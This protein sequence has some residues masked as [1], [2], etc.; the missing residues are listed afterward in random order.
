M[1]VSLILG[2]L[3]Q[4][5]PETIIIDQNLARGGP[6]RRHLY[7]HPRPIWQARPFL[8]GMEAPG[9]RCSRGAL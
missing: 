1:G 3:P 9:P 6:T 5:Y 8:S 7:R 4:A 2:C